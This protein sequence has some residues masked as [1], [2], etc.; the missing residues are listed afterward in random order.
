MS[1]LSAQPFG[2]N[3][4]FNA[5]HSPMGAFF[6]FTCGNPGTQGGMACESGR[7]GTQDVFVGYK[8]GP[9]GKPGTLVCL[10]LFTGAKDNAASAFLVEQADKKSPTDSRVV[11]YTADQ[12]K[13]YYGWA[14]D[15][16]VTPD[17]Q[18]TIYTPFGSIPDP[19]KASAGEMREA[20]AP[21][22]IAELT[23]DNTHGTEV[24]TGF[25]ALQFSAP[26]MRV[27]DETLGDGRLGFAWRRDMGF[28]GE[29]V[30]D[31]A[32]APLA[33]CHF[34]PQQG[35]SEVNYRLHHLGAAPGIAF[36]VAPGHKRTLR[37]AIG[38]YLDGKVTTRL[39]GRYL[40]TRYFGGLADVLGYALDRYEQTVL[41]CVERDQEL[42]SSKLSA[43]QQFLLAHSTRSYYGSTQLLEVGG[44]PFWIVNEGEYCMLNT[45]D[46]SVDHVF[47][48]LKHNPWLVRNLL[49]NFVRFYSY[50][51]QVKVPDGKGGFTLAPGGI[52]F[53]HDMGIHNNFSPLTHSSY[54]LTNLDG[55]FSHMT[56]EQVCNW[57]LMAGSYMATTNDMEWLTN[58]W[59]IVH[60]CLLSMQN[61]DH[62]DAAKRTGV[63]QL[64][65]SRC[66][67]GAEITTYDSLDHSLA[68]SRNNLYIAVKCWATYLSLA[69]MFQKLGDTK[70]KEQALKSAGLAARTVTAKMTDAGFIPAVFEEGNPG[71]LSRI[72]PAIEGLVY[73]LYW[74]QLGSEIAAAALD[75]EGAFASMLSALERHTRTLLADEGNRFPDGGLRLSSTSGNSWMSKIALFQHVARKY[76][77]IEKGDARQKAADAAHVKWQT[78]GNGTY[79]AMSDQ[80]LNGVA[81]GSKYYPRC[82]TTVLWMDE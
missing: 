6:S 12:I 70:H 29:I 31:G 65:S 58:N 61:R 5:H 46:L 76:Y 77:G 74:K 19:A 71:H 59:P 11:A 42:A 62:A 48:E 69:I 51:D 43:D 63:M 66:G 68:Q 41:R 3:T 55:C 80:I 81:Q 25:F 17:L 27:L 47:W 32:S 10:P 35:L 28:V 36:E 38:C 73:P 79:W 18:L 21:A 30:P 7:P 23:I 24:K 14:S 8:T 34:T 64:D 45:L 22:V 20:I 1:T 37:L 60:D 33:F 72:L 40:Y 82:V 78:V 15:R 53:C 56:V 50:R 13:R 54:E 49:E 39:E 52:S 75:D 57:T 4:G 2:G 67:I 26:G 44:Q 16:W 9:V